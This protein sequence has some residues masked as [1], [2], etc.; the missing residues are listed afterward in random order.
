[1]RLLPILSLVLSIAAIP[2]A[3]AAPRIGEAAPAFS[4]VDSN[5]KTVA[6][7][8]FKGKYV[9]LEWTN[10][11]CPF[12]KKH[13]GSGNMQATQKEAVAQGAAWL[14]VISSKRGAQGHVDGKGAN[15]LTAERDAAPTHVLLDEKGEVGR[16]YDAKT[17]PHMFIVDPDGKLIYNGAIDSV[18]SS[19]PA[20]IDEATNYVKVALA[21]ARAGKPVS[22]AVTKPYGCNVK[23]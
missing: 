17:T 15:K 5:G 22:T 1:M 7:A 18:P 8:D 14:S 21:E 20:D 12:V 3:Q 16:L 6:L 10:D 13:Y 11:G 4:A 19:D 23:Y 9:V 2:V